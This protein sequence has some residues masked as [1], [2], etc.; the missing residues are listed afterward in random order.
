VENF[1]LNKTGFV[2]SHT[3][4]R[5]V[6]ILGVVALTMSPAGF[7]QSL[8]LLA[9]THYFLALIYSK[10]QIANALSGVSRAIP[11]LITITA[12]AFLMPQLR[13]NLIFYFGVHHVF[14]EVYLLQREVHS[15]QIAETKWLRFW[16]LVFNFFLY[17]SVVHDHARNLPLE[18]LLVG[19]SLS[20]VGYFAS[21][22]SLRKRLTLRQIIDT[23]AVELISFGLLALSFHTKIQ[24]I[25]YVAY[26]V[27]FWAIYP[28]PK[29]MKNGKLKSYLALNALILSVVW[30][31]SPLGPVHTAVQVWTR[32]FLTLSV[33]HISMSFALSSAQPGWLNRLFRVPTPQAPMQPVHQTPGQLGGAAGD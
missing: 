27:I 4:M 22:W 11:L 25:H 33:V 24:L 32:I 1:S 23:S 19:L 28:V 10:R 16:A 7:Y 9:N 3:I 17:L 18:Q 20:G 6:A 26:H 5:V 13:A 15:G 12:A 14:T 31:L 29:A 21:L 30:L 2:S 8:L